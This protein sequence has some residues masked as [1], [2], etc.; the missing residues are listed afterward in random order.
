LNQ[1][2]PEQVPYSRSENR[3][4]GGAWRVRRNVKRV[5]PGILLAA[6]ASILLL[7]AP[8]SSPHVAFLGRVPGTDSYS[9]LDPYAR[10]GAP[11]RGR[12]A[13]TDIATAESLG[14]SFGLPVCTKGLT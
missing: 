12:L 4:S 6:T 13:A 9:A 5:C 10:C 11:R 3:K 8:V 2:K 1:G 7:L 14:S